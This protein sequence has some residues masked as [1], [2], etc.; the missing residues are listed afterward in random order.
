MLPEGPWCDHPRRC[1][2]MPPDFRL[3]RML[4]TIAEKQNEVRAPLANL[5]AFAILDRPITRQG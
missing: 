4:K 1:A 5:I 3:A 2:A